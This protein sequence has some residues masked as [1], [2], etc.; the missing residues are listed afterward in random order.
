MKRE[1]KR[2]NM[3]EI[4]K[5]SS[6]NIFETHLLSMKIKGKDKKEG[7]GKNMKEIGKERNEMITYKRR[8]MSAEIR[9]EKIEREREILKR[10]KRRLK[11]MK[12]DEKK[13]VN[14]IGM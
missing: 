9:G 4:G 7:K 1:G 10:G 12:K 5:K 13:K 6:E 8:L 11:F 2:E 3:E 14:R